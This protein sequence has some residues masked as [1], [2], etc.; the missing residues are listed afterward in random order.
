MPWPEVLLFM[1]TMEFLALYGL[2]LSGHFPAEYRS[3]DLK[4][5]AGV[6]ILWTTL[7]FVLMATILLL[8]A[9]LVILPLS[10]I[11]IGG[12]AMLLA[13]PLILRQFPDRVVNGRAILIVCAAGTLVTAFGLWVHK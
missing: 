9:A 2:S 12:G 4:T 1:L 3:L 5:G 7:A 11:I 6:I 8:D 13:A 10:A